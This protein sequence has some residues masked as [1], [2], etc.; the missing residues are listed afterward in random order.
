[1]VKK[2]VKNSP[3]TNWIGAIFAIAPLIIWVAMYFVELK[4]EPNELV[5]GAISGVGLALW[6][7]FKDEMFATAFGWLK[8]K[9]G[10][11]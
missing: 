10:A 7:G 4:K 8:N 6:F 2:N 3:Y 1:M 9:F 5:L 11:K